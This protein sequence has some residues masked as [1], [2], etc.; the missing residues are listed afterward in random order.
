MEHFA[1]IAEQPE[2]KRLLEGALAEGP[3]HAFLL[4]GPPGV[5]KKTAAYAFAVG[6]ARGR[7]PGR[8]PARI[9]ISTCSSRSA[10]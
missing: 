2:A 7:A 9:P 8:R 1:E 3:A 6:A 4:H 10:R 5:G